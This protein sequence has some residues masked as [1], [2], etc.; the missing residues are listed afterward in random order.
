MGMKECCPRNPK[1]VNIF[2]L[3]VSPPVR[4]G[5]RFL[6]FLDG[7]RDGIKSKIIEIS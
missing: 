6:G 2:E 4:Q 3:N 1:N 7:M 5:F